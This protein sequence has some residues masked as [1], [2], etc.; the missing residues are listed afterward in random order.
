[1]LE[2]PPKEWFALVK[3]LRNRARKDARPDPRD[4]RER[5]A[6]EGSRR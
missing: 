1:M 6:G 5:A 3:E 2:E 4:E